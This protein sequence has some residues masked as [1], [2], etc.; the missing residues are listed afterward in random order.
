MFLLPSGPHDAF[1][2]SHEER[3]VAVWRVSSNRTGIKN[4][5]IMPYQIKEALMEPRVWLLAV[6]QLSIGIVN[7]GV[8]NFTSSLLLGFGFSAEKTLLYQLPNGAVQVFCTIVAGIIT[9]TVPKSLVITIALV[10]LP[11]LAGVIGIRL[12]PLDNQLSL[13]ACC[14]LFGA[15]GAA[16]ILNWSVVASNFAGHSKRMTVNGLNFVFYYAGNIIG[17]FL[18]ISSESPKY[19]T[20]VS[21]MVSVFCVSIA[22]T[23]LTG[24]LMAMENRR[25]DK[26]AAASNEGPPILADEARVFEG[27]T[28]HTDKEM[29]E[30]RYRW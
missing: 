30:F 14:W 27:F 10:Q 5:Q 12:I 24:L 9:S 18:F 17:P 3:L 6:Q 13:A 19:P 11:A 15:Y 2:L 22:S 7:G 21:G 29:K 20:A 26:E 28:D 25:R 23:L 8:S 1:F 4:P 16:V